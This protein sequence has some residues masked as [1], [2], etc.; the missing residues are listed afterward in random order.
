[1]IE[2]KE[3]IQAPSMAKIAR[4]TLVAAVVAVVILLVAVLPA[5][6]GIDPLGTGKE[7]GLMGLANAAAAKPAPAPEPAV[8]SPSPAPAADASGHSEPAEHG[9]PT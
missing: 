6:Y 8:D 5:E 9:R 1:M 3:I 2:E 4:A 7:L